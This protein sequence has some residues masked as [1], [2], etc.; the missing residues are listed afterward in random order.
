MKPV[1]PDLFAPAKP[2]SPEPFEFTGANC[3]SRPEW[4]V[5]EWLSLPTD[6]PDFQP[7]G[8]FG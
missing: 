4:V 5:P 7:K 2:E 8:R 3:E 1:Q 6:D